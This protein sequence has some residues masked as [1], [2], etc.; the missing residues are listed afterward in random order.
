MQTP[1]TVRATLVAARHAQKLSQRALAERMGI[2]QPAL[3]R[4]ESGAREPGL[5]NLL[6][7]VDA[8]GLT[9][10]LTPTGEDQ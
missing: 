10:T 1:E 4:W 5:A 3:A 6:R 7:W 8:L 9:L 2:H